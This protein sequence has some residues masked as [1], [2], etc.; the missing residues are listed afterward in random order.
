MEVFNIRS[1]I[2]A[3]VKKAMAGEE[4]QAEVLVKVSVMLRIPIEMVEKRVEQLPALEK[5]LKA[6]QRQ[7]SDARAQL[8]VITAD[9]NNGSGYIED[10]EDAQ[11]EL[12]DLFKERSS[13]RGVRSSIQDFYYAVSTQAANIVKNMV[14]H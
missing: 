13:V 1:S 14:S 10:V 7:I 8:A 5:R 3:I 4:E 6:V 9:Y 11:D 2:E 12:N